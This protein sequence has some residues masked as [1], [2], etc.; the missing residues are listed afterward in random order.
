MI[1]RRGALTKVASTKRGRSGRSILFARSGKEGRLFSY[2]RLYKRW[3]LSGGKAHSWSGISARDKM[4]AMVDFAE[5]A[6]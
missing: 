5:G 3:T 4:K 1:V 6:L 2:I